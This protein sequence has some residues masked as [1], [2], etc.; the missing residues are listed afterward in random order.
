M[1][2]RDRATYFRRLHT[3]GPLVLPNAWDAASARAIELAGAS[4]VG[5]TS[6]GISWGY[7][8]GDGRMGRDEMIRVVHHIVQTVDIP[9]TADVEGGY[10]TGSAQDIAETVHAVIDVG[11]VGINLEDS[12]GHGGKPLLAPAGQ[13]ER[14]HAAREAAL[15]AGGDLVINART[16][17]YLA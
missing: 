6:A 9:V 15:A 2:Q 3:D 10:G 12:P 5:T 4:A 16:D 13:A 11:A 1:G 14:I 8:R 17:V 7:G